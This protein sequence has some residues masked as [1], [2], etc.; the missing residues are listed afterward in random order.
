LR[1]SLSR[2][3]P[4]NQRGAQLL[5]EAMP[6]DE[7]GKL[8]VEDRVQK[9]PRSTDKPAI[10]KVNHG[11]PTEVAGVTKTKYRSTQYIQ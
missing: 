8:Q 5:G 6:Y 1:D 7:P 4:Y 3:P 9:T 2:N 11:I 10:Q